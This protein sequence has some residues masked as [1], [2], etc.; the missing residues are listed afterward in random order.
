MND[1]AA[2]IE[3]KTH[4]AFAPPP[5]GGRIE[6]RYVRP[7]DLPSGRFAIIEKSKEFTLVPWREALEKRRGL[8]I[9]G[10]MGRG[11]VSWEF[12]KTRGGPAR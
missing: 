9:S 4:K 1:A 8:E 6:G 3:K 7:V 12:G 10:V 2:A 11:G 5:E